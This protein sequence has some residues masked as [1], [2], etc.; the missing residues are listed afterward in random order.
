MLNNQQLNGAQIQQ[1]LMANALSSRRGKP[2]VRGIQVNPM[3]LA[4]YDS[5][6]NLLA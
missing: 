4:Q 1:K 6:G 5:A 2:T 3:S